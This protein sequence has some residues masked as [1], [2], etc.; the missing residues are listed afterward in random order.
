MREGATPV[1]TTLCVR[2]G[3]CRVAGLGEAGHGLWRRNEG[4]VHG[5]RASGEAHR[6][7]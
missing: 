6:Y 5:G 7:T 3:T 4:R 1:S 2:I